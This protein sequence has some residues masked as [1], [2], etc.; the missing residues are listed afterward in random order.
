MTFFS[1]G[2]NVDFLAQAKFKE[3]SA[4]AFPVDFGTNG[5]HGALLV[6]LGQAVRV[7]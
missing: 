7:F 3:G 4:K 2:P 5:D 6:L 1:S